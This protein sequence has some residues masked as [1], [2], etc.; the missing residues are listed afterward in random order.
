L[1]V[2]PKVLAWLE[3]CPYHNIVGEGDRLG[4]LP[5][6]LAVQESG[7][8]LT[9]VYLHTPRPLAMQRCYERD[10]RQSLAW[11]EGRMSH[12]QSLVARFNA[13]PW[14]WTLDGTL[15]LYLLAEQLASHPCIQGLERKALENPLKS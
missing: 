9:V 3:N 5:F 1:S 2:Q 10:S 8:E 11:W 14:L 7:W 6:F 13:S 4:N 15:P 12:V